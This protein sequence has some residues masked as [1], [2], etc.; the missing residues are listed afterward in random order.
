[1]LTALNRK[2]EGPGPRA[3]PTEAASSL[4]VFGADL[5]CCQLA[6]F[7][8]TA[9]NRKNE[10]PGHPPSFEA[11]LFGSLRLKWQQRASAIE[12]HQKQSS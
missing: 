12:K 10:G 1:M 11:D 2:N 6:V 9:L 4:R 8:L 3:K 5:A 7:L